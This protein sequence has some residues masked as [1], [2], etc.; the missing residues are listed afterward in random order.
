[1]LASSEY[2]VEL[3]GL[4]GYKYRDVSGIVMKKFNLL[5][6][7]VIVLALPIS[8]FLKLLIDQ[9]FEHE[10]GIELGLGVSW[11]TILSGCF[12][13]GVFYVIQLL[14]IRAAVKKAISLS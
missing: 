4:L 6:A 10:L 12:V 7:L 8:Y 5:F 11:A 1:M 14:M 9:Q 2:E 13:Y 3:L